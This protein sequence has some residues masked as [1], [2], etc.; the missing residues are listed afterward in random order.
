MRLV[1][2]INHATRMPD[3]WFDE[4]DDLDR[5]AM[6]VAAIDDIDDPVEAAGVLA[7]RV[8]RAQGFGEGNKRT[9]F[10]L[11]RWLLDYNGLDGPALMP[12]DDREM[13]DLLVRAAAGAD[14]KDEVVAL[15]K[16]RT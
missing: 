13:A 12:P 3:E 9:A 5:V 6:A 4:A 7:A 8:A 10:L 16:S 15:L 11:A 14:V 1:V 2:A